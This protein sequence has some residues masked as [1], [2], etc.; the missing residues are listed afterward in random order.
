MNE[1]THE[2]PNEQENEHAELGHLAG[3]LAA[4]L[5]R[6]SRRG[7]TRISKERPLNQTARSE[8]AATT[9]LA[10]KTPPAPVAAQAPALA[11][12]AEPAKELKTAAKPQGTPFAIP[13]ASHEKGLDLPPTNREIA[14]GCADL[15][16]LRTA[17]AACQAC[18]L[19]QTRK[20]TAFLDGSGSCGVLFVG[21]GPGERDDAT[22]V[23][24]S[25]QSG[26]LLTDII[27]KGMKL[28]RREVAIAN[29]LKC[30]VPEEQEPSA[31][32]KERCAP[33]LDRQIELLNPKVII[34]LGGQASNH[35]LGTQLPMTR[36]RGRAHDVGGRK[37]VPT[38]HPTY[39]LRTPSMKKEC[40]KDI[41]IAL[42]ELA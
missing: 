18:D 36:L 8:S 38:Y 25:G 31:L 3:A 40:W 41:Q 13:A 24:F 26:A 1:H 22:G 42:H 10:S 21:T 17:V 16:S 27:T 12:V 33:F 37:V 28:E 6:R 29:L 4:H 20:Q 15:A 34:T 35:I 9:P 14:N 39:L 7:V 32:Q 30:R 2:H 23:P 11:Q 19:C 5:E